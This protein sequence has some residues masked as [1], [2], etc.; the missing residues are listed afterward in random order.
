MSI[1]LLKLYNTDSIAA[2]TGGLGG[3]AFGK[4]AIPSSWQEQIQDAEF[5]LNIGEYL[6][7]VAAGEP[8]TFQIRPGMAG[9]KSKQK[10]S[11][12]DVKVDMRVVHS[13][14]GLGQVIHVSQQSLLTKDKTVTVITIKF[15]VGQSCTFAFRSDAKSDTLFVV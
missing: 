5:L 15:D 7:S 14:L 13:R 9:V 8:K 4:E 11:R 3:A 1:L 10:L 2:F 12:L 6:A